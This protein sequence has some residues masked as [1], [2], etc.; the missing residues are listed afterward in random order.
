MNPKTLYILNQLTLI[1]IAY[2]SDFKKRNVQ[3]GVFI[4]EEFMILCDFYD[5]L[6]TNKTFV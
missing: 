1:L 2:K 6:R 3:F 4:Q 5:I